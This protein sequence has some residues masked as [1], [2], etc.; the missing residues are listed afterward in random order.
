MNTGY[1]CDCGDP[2]CSRCY[3]SVAATANRK[4]EA[5]SDMADQ[6]QSEAA[7]RVGAALGGQMEREA[8]IR[9]LTGWVKALAKLEPETLRDGIE[10]EALQ[11]LFVAVGELDEALIAAVECETVEDRAERR[12]EQAIEDRE[13]ERWERSRE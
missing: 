3:G 13:V 5:V 9:N 12:I 11:D 8:R 6:M 2:C 7:S 1:R 10:W 4:A